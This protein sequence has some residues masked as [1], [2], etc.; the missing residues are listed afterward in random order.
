MIGMGFLFLN[1]SFFFLQRFVFTFDGGQAGRCL[2]GALVSCH[3]S[4]PLALGVDDDA[5]VLHL[6]LYGD[7]DV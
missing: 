6:S 1:N 4:S 5:C 3:A 2:I 7:D